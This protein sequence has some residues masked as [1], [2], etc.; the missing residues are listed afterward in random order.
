V[1]V[2]PPGVA[3]LA[4]Q[5]GE[6]ALPD[7]GQRGGLQ[8]VAVVGLAERREVAVRVAGVVV[9]ELHAEA[10]AERRALRGAEQPVPA[11]TVRDAAGFELMPVATI[12]RTDAQFDIRRDQVGQFEVGSARGQDVLAG[13]AKVLE[14]TQRALV[15]G[16]GTTGEAIAGRQGP[17][18]R[19]G[20]AGVVEHV[21]A[22]VGLLVGADVGA[23]SLQAR[24]PVDAGTGERGPCPV[25]A[26]RIP[27]QRGGIGVVGKPEQVVVVAA[28][29]TGVGPQEIPR[30]AR[31]PGEWRQ[32]QGEQRDGAQ[33]AHGAGTWLS[34]H[35]RHAAPGRRCA[36]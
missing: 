35:W 36:G 28:G 19:S 12:A 13:V 29:D 11:A 18:G 1:V 2:A 5:L 9:A 23:D 22:V 30:Q 20:H 34:T 27:Q 26:V 16:A 4:V 8:R 14:R 17:V 33:P 15:A 6:A 31:V 24:L 21:E 3:E 32:T 25:G 10:V 7:G